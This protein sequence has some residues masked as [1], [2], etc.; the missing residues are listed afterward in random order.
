MTNFLDQVLVI[1]SLYE[2][3][4]AGRKVGDSRPTNFYHYYFSRSGVETR[5]WKQGM[6]RFNEGR[7][8]SM[9]WK[10]GRLG[11]PRE[12]T[13]LSWLNYRRRAPL[14]ETPPGYV[15]GE[16]L[17]VSIFSLK[18]TAASCLHVGWFLEPR[19]VFV[20]GRRNVWFQ[21]PSRF[22]PDLAICWSEFDRRGVDTFFF[23]RLRYVEGF[24]GYFRLMRFP[25]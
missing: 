18:S 24:G 20:R 23:N 6:E 22:S 14:V 1:V 19:C 5:R 17:I 16:E 10:L 8:S 13:Q 25:W 15:P 7:F 21:L 12:Y 9:K 3:F 4:E 2:R 11:L